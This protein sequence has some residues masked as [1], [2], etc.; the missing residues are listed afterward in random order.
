MLKD[1]P[2]E[3]VTILLPFSVVLSVTLLTVTEV[4]VLPLLP[5]FTVRVLPSLK[6]TTL[7]PPSSVDV[8]TLLTV[9]EVP[10][11][12]VLPLL[13]FFTV[14]V[15]PSLKVIT[16]LPPSAALS[17]TDCTVTE[18]PSLPFSPLLPSLPSLIVAIFV[19][20]LSAIEIVVTLPDLL[21]DNV[22]LTP[23]TP[24]NSPLAFACASAK[25]TASWNSSTVLSSVSTQI[26][27]VSLG[28]S[29]YATIDAP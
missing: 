18:I 26:T 5:F 2:S 27:E 3:K 8:L 7:F 16:L 22:G 9:T 4:P 19:P 10:L 21:T 12:P 14:R 11:L 24:S 15:F 29:F 13:P 17:L 25:F 1:L 28:A 6:V 23:S 20:F